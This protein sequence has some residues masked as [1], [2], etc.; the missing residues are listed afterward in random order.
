MV[1]IDP[2]R[3]VVRFPDV[4]RELGL[5][6]TTL[7]RICREGKGPPLLQL[8]ERRSGVRRGDLDAWVESRKLDHPQS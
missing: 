4:C 2:A 1:Q 3:A 8:S 7:R 5:S 6:A